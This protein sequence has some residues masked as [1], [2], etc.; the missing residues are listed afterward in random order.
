MTLF[1]PSGQNIFSFLSK[2]N[3]LPDDKISGLPKLKAFVDD[4]SNVT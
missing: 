4:K 2:F 3:A 1:N